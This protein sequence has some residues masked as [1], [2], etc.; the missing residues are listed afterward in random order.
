VGV[1]LVNT[2]STLARSLDEAAGLL[3]VSIG[4]ALS[5][6]GPGGD[7]LLLQAPRS[8]GAYRRA[9]RG[10]VH[11]WRPITKTTGD[12]QGRRTEP[13]ERLIR[14]GIPLGP[15]SPPLPSFLNA[16]QLFVDTFSVGML[17]DSSHLVHHRYQRQSADL[18]P[19][20]KR[21][22]GLGMAGNL[23]NVG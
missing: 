14:A 10:C 16:L 2:V 22:P 18:S 4:N 7:R 1:G 9:D 12:P 11:R 5:K 3:L 8:V 20:Q 15:N 13:V 6:I 19:K 21:D 23:A 17:A